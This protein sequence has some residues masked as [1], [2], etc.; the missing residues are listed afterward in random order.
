[1]KNRF[2]LLAK[3]ALNDIFY[4]RK[5][6][7]CIIASLVAVIAPLL[8]L[9]SLKY[10]IVS[11]LRHQLV[12]DPT[13]LEIKIV[14]NLNLSQDWFDWLKQQS[15][16]QFSIPLTRSLNTIIDLKKEANFVRNVELIP[17][18]SGD[19]ITQQ[20][21]QNENSI[22]LSALSA[23]KLQ[24]KQG[25]SITL[26]ATRNENGQEE[27]ALLPLKV[28]AILNEQQFPRAAIFVPMSLL[29]G[30]EDFRDGMKTELFPAAS[31]KPN[32]KLRKNFARARIYAKSL[33]DVAPLALKLREQFHIDTR[34]ESKAIENVKAIDSVLNVIFMVIAFT[35]VVG[36]VLS[37]IGAFLANIDRKRK[38][39]A[40]LR[41]I[42]FQQSAVG[43]YL[44]FQAI[45]LSSIAFILSYGLYLFGS[46]LFNQILGTGLSGSHFVSRLAPIHLCLAFI[47]SFLLAGVVA[48]IGAVR[49]VKIQPAESLRDV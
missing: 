44:I 3:L 14:G 26:V 21:L 22:I 4:D 1:M 37:L 8:L 32:D 5:V 47:F 35:S 9:F 48:A 36:C 41:L 28:Q 19:P 30:V 31:G 43:I 2:T 20:S 23:E 29:I 46:Q 27:K 13:N 6:S 24:A 45:V 38:D 49:A 42:G 7:F 34:T 40:V 17:T 18:T 16:T 25:E 15:E 12:N 10:G 33:D 11:Q 39:I